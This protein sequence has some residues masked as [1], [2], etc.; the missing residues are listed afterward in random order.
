MLYNLVVVDQ[1]VWQMIYTPVLNGLGFRLLRITVVRCKP[2]FCWVIN[3]KLASNSINDLIIIEKLWPS[4]SHTK[5][6][7]KHNQSIWRDI[8]SVKIVIHLF[9]SFF[10]NTYSSKQKSSS[11]GLSKDRKCTTYCS[12]QEDTK[13]LDACS[14]KR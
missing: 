11:L 2:N 9:F 8:R 5:K 10:W 12:K 4:R 1:H 6:W 13:I 7:R 14:K 3:T